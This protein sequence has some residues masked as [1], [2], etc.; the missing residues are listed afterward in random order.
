MTA[1]EYEKINSQK[2]KDKELQWINHKSFRTCSHKNYRKTMRNCSHSYNNLISWLIWLIYLFFIPNL[3][4]SNQISTLQCS[5]APSSIYLADILTPKL[6]FCTRQGT[7][8]LTITKER[9]SSNA[10]FVM[11]RCFFKDIISKNV[12]FYVLNAAFQ[13]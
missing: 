3:S 5:Q 9:V 10:K 6:V 13:F 12:L 8:K 4:Y 2:T 1:S 7:Q 11:L